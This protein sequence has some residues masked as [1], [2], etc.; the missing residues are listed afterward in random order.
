M[1]GVEKSF[2]IGD[3]RRFEM[4]STWVLGAIRNISYDGYILV[5]DICGNSHKL[6]IDVVTPVSPKLDASLRTDLE[7]LAELC[8]LFYSNENRYKGL[9]QEYNSLS[10]NQGF[11][12]ASVKEDMYKLDKAFD[13]ISMKFQKVIN[14]LA[15]KYPKEMAYNY[16]E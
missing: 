12:R 16:S 1:F 6:P 3:I 13:E 2:K 5:Y 14:K 11:K 10:E 4:G 7:E 8:K 15:N 9:E